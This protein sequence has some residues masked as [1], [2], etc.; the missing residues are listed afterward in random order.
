MHGPQDHNLYWR[1]HGLWY[2]VKQ[3]LIA[4]AHQTFIY[5]LNTKGFLLSEKDVHFS[6][7][8]WLGK[9]QSEYFRVV[10]ANKK[11]KMDWE[12]IFNAI[13]GHFQCNRFIVGDKILFHGIELF[14]VMEIKKTGGGGEEAYLYHVKSGFSTAT[15][16]ACAQIQNA[17][18]IIRNPLKTIFKELERFYED[19]K[20]KSQNKTIFGKI[21]SE[22]FVGLL[23]KAK[24]VYAVFDDSKLSKRYPCRYK[25]NEKICRS[26]I[27]EKA[28]KRSVTVKLLESALREND[29][30]K[31]VSGLNLDH[32]KDLLKITGSRQGF[33][34]CA[35][36]IVDLL[37]KDNYLD[38]QNEATKEFLT[39]SQ[40]DF[41]LHGVNKTGSE[42]ILKCLNHFRSSYLSRTFVPHLEIIRTWFDLRENFLIY[43]ISAE[44]DDTPPNKFHKLYFE[45]THPITPS[46]S[47]VV[48][49]G[50]ESN[51]TPSSNTEQSQF[52][53]P[54]ES[55]SSSGYA[56][57]T[58]TFSDVNRVI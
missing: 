20:R 26:L 41:K 18:R 49:S 46:T 17:F 14:D 55:G 56:S 48:D 1:I 6:Q 16:E 19:I 38:E 12:G 32:L 33:Q 58:P 42:R 36:A 57:A 24:F 4:R 31:N 25:N 10:K 47:Q 21:T 39:V 15:R 23:Q 27:Q 9:A 53:M 50:I 3:D 40:Q 44:S 37:R 13:F 7:N 34:V 22:K 30:K 5:L 45:A 2:E 54:V 29:K 51:L 43:E 11:E 28:T 35:E 52:V 8:K